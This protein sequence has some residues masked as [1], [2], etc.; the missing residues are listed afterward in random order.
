MPRR[1]KATALTSGRDGE[2]EMSE[3]RQH[4]GA[5]CGLPGRM[6]LP[7]PPAH[8]CRVRSRPGVP[9]RPAP[10]QGAAS[11]PAELRCPIGGAV[12]GRSPG[13]IGA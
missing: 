4:S 13:R 7:R 9:R 3:T 8:L 12:I 1:R 5:G 10:A 6:G 11:A 2:I